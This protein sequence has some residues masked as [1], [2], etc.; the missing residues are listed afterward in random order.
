MITF[1]EAA[2][3][4]YGA[5]RLACAD[6]NG[7]DY[8]NATVEGFWRSF[9]AAVLVAPL[10][11]PLPLIRYGMGHVAASPPRYIAIEIV[12]Y[13]FF[14]VAF[15]VAAL[16]VSELMGRRHRFF[17]FMVAYNWAMVLQYL[18]YLPVVVLAGLGVLST[19][20]QATLE[21]IVLAL[22]LVYSWFIAR[23]GLD[24]SGPAAAGI[25]LLDFSI[26]V[27]INLVSDAMAQIG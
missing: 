3:S 12:A 4:L 5:Y 18:V 20:A 26:G 27:A 10:Y 7:L 2:L 15:P 1:R 19:G 9:F 22:L 17:R 24:I 21:L 23:V 13:V 25:V 6:K 14:W 11:A 8:F 16:T